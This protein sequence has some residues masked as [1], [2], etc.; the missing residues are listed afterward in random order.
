[1]LDRIGMFTSDLVHVRRVVCRPARTATSGIEYADDDTLVLPVRGVFTKHLARHRQVLAEPTQAL[2]FAADRPYRVSHPS[3]AGDECIVF[4]FAPELLHDALGD[5]PVRP[6][7]VLSPGAILAR[8]LVHRRLMRGQA[9][10]LDVDETAVAMLGDV[11]RAAREGHASSSLAVR[12][13]TRHRR[14]EQAEAVQLRI[15]ADPSDDAGLASLARTAHTTPWHLARLFRAEVGIPIH[16]YRLRVRLARA[17]TLLLDTDRP[18]TRIALE[19]G[20]SSH[21][22]FTAVFRRMTGVGPGRVRRGMRLEEVRRILIEVGSG[23][24]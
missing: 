7:A 10:P 12:P 24:R 22:H 23:I 6:C 19:V 2:F 21:S 1:M 16:Q 11:V 14:R 9:D 15:L 13:R 5:D 4:R 18:L 17:V 20:F 8:D 3:L